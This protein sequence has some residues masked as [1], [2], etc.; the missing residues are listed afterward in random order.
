MNKRILKIDADASWGHD[1]K[2]MCS[3]RFNG[4][5][6][7]NDMLFIELGG[8]DAREFLRLAQAIAGQESRTTDQLI[9]ALDERRT[10]EAT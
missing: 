2:P 1:S 4:V 10:L 6:H 3:V 8:E 9:R 7:D 5:D